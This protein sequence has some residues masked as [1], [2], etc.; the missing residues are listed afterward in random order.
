MTVVSLE[1]AERGPYQGGVSFGEAGPYEYLTGVLHFAIDPRSPANELICDV[2]LA[3]KN[4]R[5]QVEFSAQFHLLTPVEPQADGRLL[6]DSPNRGN[7][8]ALAMF[9]GAARRSGATADVDPGNG[10][11]MRSRYSIVSVAIQWDA[12]N[13]PE[14]LRAVFPEAFRD[15]RRLQ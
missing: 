7:M 6:V 2:G 11:L 14:R 3:P 9:N 12:P 10:Y 8:S 4:A 15:G 5:G 13:S 1:V